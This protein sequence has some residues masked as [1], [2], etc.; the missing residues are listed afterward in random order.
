MHDWDPKYGIRDVYRIVFAK[1]RRLFRIGAEQ[2][3]RGHLP[4]SVAALARLYWRQQRLI[5][6][7]PVSN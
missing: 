6:R 5:G 2:R 7:Y 1:Q 3:R 4:I